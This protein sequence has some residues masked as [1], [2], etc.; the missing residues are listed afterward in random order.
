MSIFN[1]GNWS[2]RGR[3]QNLPSVKR[4]TYLEVSQGKVIDELRNLQRLK[5][6]VTEGHSDDELLSTTAQCHGGDA[7]PMSIDVLIGVAREQ[8]ILDLDEV[9]GRSVE[10][11]LPLVAVC[12]LWNNQ[13]M[14][15]FDSM[16]SEQS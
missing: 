9:A 4:A 5:D 11:H 15:E 16:Q 13:T 7:F 14:A 3:R 12:V 8:N 1:D 6:R 2:F 10:G